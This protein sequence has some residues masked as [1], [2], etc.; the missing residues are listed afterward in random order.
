MRIFTVY[1]EIPFT[2]VMFH[3]PNLHNERIGK[4]VEFEAGLI[5]GSSSSGLGSASDAESSQLES[6]QEDLADAF[7]DLTPDDASPGK[8][9]C[10][11]SPFSKLSQLDQKPQTGSVQTHL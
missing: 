3:H 8:Q 11:P 2:F 4:D 7:Q 1:S 10:L 5:A 9:P 6:D